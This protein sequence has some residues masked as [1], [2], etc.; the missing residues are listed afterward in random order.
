MVEVLFSILPKIHAGPIEKPINDF[1]KM[2]KKVGA[3]DSL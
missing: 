3:K 2:P 1:F